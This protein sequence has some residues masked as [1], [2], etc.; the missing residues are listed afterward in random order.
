MFKLFQRFHFTEIPVN[1]FRRRSH[2]INSVF[3]VVAFE[4]KRAY[5]SP[6][7]RTTEVIIEPVFQVFNTVVT[8]P[9]MFFGVALL[10]S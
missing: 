6:A 10:R 3:R 5:W 7:A 8:V 1:I 2:E 9:Q 4:D